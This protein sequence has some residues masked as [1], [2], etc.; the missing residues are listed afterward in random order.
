V[1]SV[2][3]EALGV[4]RDVRRRIPRQGGRPDGHARAARD[5]RRQGKRGT[6]GVGSARRESV[7]RLGGV[8]RNVVRR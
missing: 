2:R 1:R 4:L 6:S 8:F 3:D 5:G 7:H